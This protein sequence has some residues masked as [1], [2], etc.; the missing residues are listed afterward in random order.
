MIAILLKSILAGFLM[1]LILL[2]PFFGAFTVGLLLIPVCLVPNVTI[3]QFCKS[4]EYVEF[5][6]AWV[7]LHSAQPF[8]FYWAWYFI[9]AF[10]LYKF[11][12]FR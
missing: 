11:A 3:Q 12:K 5:G 4:S 6:F 8:F 10:A 2:I 9:V 1:T 7:I